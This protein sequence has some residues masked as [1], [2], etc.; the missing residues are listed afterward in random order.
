MSLRSIDPGDLL[1]PQ[2]GSALPH[3]HPPPVDLLRGAEAS[4]PGAACGRGAR[5][6]RGVPWRQQTWQKRPLSLRT[7]A[8]S[9]PPR[10]PRV[11]NPSG[12][13]S[14]SLALPSWG[15]ESQEKVPRLF[16]PSR[17][18]PSHTQVWGLGRGSAARARCCPGRAELRNRPRAPHSPPAR[19][20]EP[21]TDAAPS[22]SSLSRKCPLQK[23][24]SP[25]LP[26]P[27]PARQPP[28]AAGCCSFVC[29]AGSLPPRSSAG[30]GEKE[31]RLSSPAAPD[32][33]PRRSSPVLSVLPSAALGSAPLLSGAEV[34]TNYSWSEGRLR[35]PAEP[36]RK[37]TRARR[38]VESA[39][40]SSH[41]HSTGRALGAPPSLFFTS[42]LLS[43][44]PVS[45]FRSKERKLREV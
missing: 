32:S 4:S 14:S 36:A 44:L 40:P 29:P 33:A 9:R 31:A 11:S 35:V 23:T 18:L 15:L 38:T 20:S 16:G 34:Q 25:V 10:F 12:A 37:G 2:S 27:V 24:K 6:S 45:G 19:P 28:A 3:Q 41:S 7:T 5:R 39:L 42:F 8:G 26:L 17:V 30:S 21:H 13:R 1:L 22:C 43:L